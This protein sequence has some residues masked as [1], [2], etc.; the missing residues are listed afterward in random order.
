MNKEFPLDLIFIIFAVALGIIGSIALVVIQPYNPISADIIQLWI[1]SLMI[2]LIFLQ[3]YWSKRQ[4]IKSEEEI[5]KNAFVRLNEYFNIILQSKDKRKNPIMAL[6]YFRAHSDI[7]LKIGIE[8]NDNPDRSDISHLRILDQYDL[9]M[10][11]GM[12]LAD[13]LQVVNSK[14]NGLDQCKK[15]ESKD[16]FKEIKIRMIKNANELY[17][18]NLSEKLAESI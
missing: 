4:Q 16:E 17:N 7:L 9:N 3:F 13:L 10:G 2:I 14:A 6:P 15:I 11:T 18:L 1:L 8:V 12:V 5:I